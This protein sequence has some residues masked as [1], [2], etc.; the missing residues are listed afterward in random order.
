MMT[1]QHVLARPFLNGSTSPLRWLSSESGGSSNPGGSG[2]TALAGGAGGAGPVLWGRSGEEAEDKARGMGVEPSFPATRGVGVAP[3]G[4]V[5]T[6][7][8]QV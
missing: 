1:W 6:D 5:G 2:A 3:P 4:G 8:T 7:V